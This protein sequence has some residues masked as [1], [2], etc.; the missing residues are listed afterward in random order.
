MEDNVCA[1]ENDNLPDAP[2]WLHRLNEEGQRVTSDLGKLD[3]FISSQAFR[4]LQDEEREMLRYQRQCMSMYQDA[5]RKRFEY[6]MGKY[7]IEALT[8]SV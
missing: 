8:I 3:T 2:D 5:V 4:N 7:S 1:P 6:Y